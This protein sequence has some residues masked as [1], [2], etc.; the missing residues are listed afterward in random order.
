MH[1]T[2]QTEDYSSHRDNITVTSVELKQRACI[3]GLENVGLSRSNLR[4]QLDRD[5]M[6]IYDFLSNRNVCVCV[7]AHYVHFM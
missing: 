1:V 3:T 5:E 2:F 6:E 4:A 7:F